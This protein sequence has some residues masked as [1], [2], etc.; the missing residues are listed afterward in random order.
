MRRLIFIFE[1]A[2]LFLNMATRKLNPHTQRSHNSGFRRFAAWLRRWPERAMADD[3]RRFRLH[4]IESGA[5]TTNRNG[6]VP[7]VRLLFRVTLRRHVLAA[8]VWH[9]KEPQ[10]LPRC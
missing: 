7:G 6:I 3:A 2:G 1:A 4:L 9:I 10:K 8:E 5:S